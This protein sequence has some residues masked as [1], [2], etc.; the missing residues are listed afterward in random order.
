[1][2]K[3]AKQWLVWVSNPKVDVIGNPIR[4]DLGELQCDRI[5]IAM[6]GVVPDEVPIEIQ[7]EWELKDW[8]FEDPTKERIEKQGGPPRVTLPPIMTQKMDHHIKRMTGRGIPPRPVQP[9]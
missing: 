7:Q 8:I 2:A 3:V 5:E 6:E 9:T 1:M 4:N